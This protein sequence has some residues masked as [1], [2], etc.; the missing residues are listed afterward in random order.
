M[1]Y[2]GI[3]RLLSAREQILTMNQPRRLF[4]AQSL[5]SSEQNLLRVATN[6]WGDQVIDVLGLIETNIRS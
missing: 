6:V 1:L 3:V 2:V 4:Q 5:K